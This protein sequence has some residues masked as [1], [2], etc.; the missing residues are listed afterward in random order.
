MTAQSSSSYK[1]FYFLY[2]AMVDPR[3]PAPAPGTLPAEMTPGG[4]GMP[5]AGTD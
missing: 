2:E 5:V 3:F 4:N 1:S